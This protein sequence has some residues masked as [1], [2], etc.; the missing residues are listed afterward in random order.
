MLRRSRTGA[1]V[2]VACTKPTAR[3]HA[4]LPARSRRAGLLASLVLVAIHGCA[5]EPVYPVTLEADTSKPSGEAGAQADAAGGAAGAPAELGSGGGRAIASGGD[6]GSAGPA[7]VVGSGG[8]PGGPSLAGQAGQAGQAG[9]A[10]AAGA[11][12]VLEGRP[13]EGYTLIG[14]PENDA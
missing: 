14:S 10:G 2:P 5:D 4:T 11:A 12:G 8:G 3:T 7:S 9:A 13:C 6:A 1:E